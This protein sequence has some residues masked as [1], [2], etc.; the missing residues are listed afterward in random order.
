MQIGISFSF[1]GYLQYKCQ[2]EAAHPYCSVVQPETNEMPGRALW[3]HLCVCCEIV[4]VCPGAPGPW[5]LCLA[6]SFLGS[7]EN[8]SVSIALRFP[9]D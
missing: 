9:L 5:D 2:K 7:E 4:V 6:L 1:V 3:F 8:K